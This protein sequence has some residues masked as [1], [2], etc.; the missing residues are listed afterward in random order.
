M[1]FFRTPS[2]LLV[3]IVPERRAYKLTSRY[4][5]NAP[6]PK[7]LALERLVFPMINS[8]LSIL[9]FMSFCA[10]TP[11]VFFLP[12]WQW[13]DLDY[14]GKECVYDVECQIISC[15]WCRSDYAVNIDYKGALLRPI[16][17]N[18]PLSFLRE[19][20][21]IY[22]GGPCAEV[23][24]KL[25]LLVLLPLATTLIYCFTC[26]HRARNVFS[27]LVSKALRGRFFN[28]KECILSR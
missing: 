10:S 16:F 14:V 23:E 7:A 12:L 8:L 15:K 24:Y 19:D 1:H 17:Q 6:S 27:L 3:V 21:S 25:V 13:I 2:A 18:I 26:R 5:V 11:L 28:N 22:E 4:L 20:D 9:T